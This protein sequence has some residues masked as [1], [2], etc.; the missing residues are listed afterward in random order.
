MGIHRVK[1]K[2]N[3]FKGEKSAE[4]K[5]RKEL[6]AIIISKFGKKDYNEIES[7]EIINLSL[8]YFITKFKGICLGETSVRFYQQIIKL[9]E[10]ATEVVYKFPHENLS[11]EIDFEYIAT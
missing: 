8:D 6:S 10:Q 5:Y 4:T 1:E 3:I 7:T 9:H 2:Y 11:D